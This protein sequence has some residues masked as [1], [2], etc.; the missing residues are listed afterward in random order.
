[1]KKIYVI[2]VIAA[3]SLFVNAGKI[4]AQNSI[5]T[6]LNLS[7]EQRAKSKELQDEYKQ[8]KEDLELQLKK[9]QKDREIAIRDQN[10]PLVERRTQEIKRTQTQLKSLAKEYGG[11]YSEILTDEQRT[12][13]KVD[14]DFYAKELA[15]EQAKME[16]SEKKPAVSS[17]AKTPA[18]AKAA[19]AKKKAPAAKK[20][21]EAVPLDEPVLM[22]EEDVEAIM[23]QQ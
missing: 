12:E 9:L 18:K 3:F 1:M 22:S 8:Q 7:D 15:A 16:A 6:Y 5:D 11:K 13:A 21:Q 20:A 14:S 23:E 10:V 4:F 2:A 17:K 19:P